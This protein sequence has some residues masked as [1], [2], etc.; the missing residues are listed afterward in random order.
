MVMNKPMKSADA[1]EELRK[2]FDLPD[3]L[4]ELHIHLKVNAPVIIETTQ[5]AKTIGGATIGELKRKWT[6]KEIV[7]D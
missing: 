6:L 5:L 1:W 3:D 4:L 2:I 7:S